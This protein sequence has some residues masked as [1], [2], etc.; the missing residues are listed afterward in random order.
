MSYALLGTLLLLLP[1][2]ASAQGSWVLQSPGQ[3]RAR[4]G[5]MVGLSC[6]TTDPSSYVNWYK[7]RADGSLSWIYRSLGNSRPLGK[8]SGRSTTAR[9][10]ALTISSV[11]REDSG[12]Y[13]CS[14][15]DTY[16]SF[17]DGTRLIVTGATQP[18]LS[19]L[20]PTDAEEP[21]Q[22]LGSIPLL[23]HLHDPPAGWDSVR[24]QPG[25]EETPLTGT[26]MDER[27]VLSAWS[28]TWVSAELW[29]G[30]AT[31]TALESGTNRTLSV[32]I[33][34]GTREGGQSTSTPT[35]DPSLDPPP[36]S[37]FPP[38]CLG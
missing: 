34:K 10:F 22:P 2:G 18:Q 4:P 28:I 33:S 13:Y 31:C 32:A 23:C 7:E 36:A 16:P 30:A 17:G 12:V 14:S 9:D 15:S 3:L 11:Q 37:Q 38:P 20:V 19:I 21:A 26:A 8:Y 24:W 27:G 35:A 29:D 5:E 6:R 25:G 1:G